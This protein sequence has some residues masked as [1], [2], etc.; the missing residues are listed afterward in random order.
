M[1]KDKLIQ[2]SG[3]KEVKKVRAEITEIKNRSTIEKTNK[4]RCWFSERTNNT[5]KLSAKL[6]NKKIEDKLS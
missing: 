4:I 3:R 6:T 2:A 5:G 1:K